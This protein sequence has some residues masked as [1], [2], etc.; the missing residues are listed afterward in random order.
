MNYTKEFELIWEQMLNRLALQKKEEVYELYLEI[1][2]MPVRNYCLEIG[3]N[4]GATTLL[5]CHLFKH[6]VS[7][8]I[9]AWTNFD[10]FKQNN[11]NV[12]FITGD[13]HSAET[14]NEVK[15][16]G[17]KFDFIFIDA[18]H[19]L[20]DVK[21][22]HEDYEKLA[23][24]NAIIGFHDILILGCNGAEVCEVYQYWAE[25]KKKYFSKEICYK[26]EEWDKSSKIEWVRLIHPSHWGGIG[27]IKL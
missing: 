5:F 7:I 18:G 10:M 14:F 15:K 17:F 21:S 22:D 24:D 3:T 23:N 9:R 25:I 27:L 26:E 8:D 16:L 19:T 12:T 6:V 1:L 4:N 20:K 2:K 13:T 11:P